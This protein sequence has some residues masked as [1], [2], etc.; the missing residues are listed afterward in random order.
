[1]W[2]D[3]TI[4]LEWFD[5]IPVGGREWG[6]KEKRE[7]RE[8]LHLLFRIS[9]AQTVVSS[10]S[11]MQSSSMRRGLIIETKIW[12]FHQAPR[13]KGFSPTRFIFGLRVIQMA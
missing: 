10:R 9:G 5:Q 12:D 2:Q 3:R 6:R 13:G 11:K 8:K 7:K 1:M 4:S